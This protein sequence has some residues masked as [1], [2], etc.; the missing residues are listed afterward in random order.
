[1]SDLWHQP[2]LLVALPAANYIASGTC[3][4]HHKLV[5]MPTS[6]PRCWEITY[7]T[8]A[9]ELQEAGTKSFSSH[10]TAQLGREQEWSFPDLSLT[11]KPLAVLLFSAPESRARARWNSS[12]GWQWIMLLPVAMSLAQKR[13]DLRECLGWASRCQHAEGM[14]SWP[15]LDNTKLRNIATSSPLSWSKS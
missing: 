5:C 9:A 4:T 12:F 1:M 8:D 7:F 3:W 11:P 15:F 2:A 14:S 6:T 10:H 13:P